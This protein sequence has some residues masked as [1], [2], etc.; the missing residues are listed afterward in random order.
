MDVDHGKTIFEIMGIEVMEWQHDSSDA[1][2]AL[3]AAEAMARRLDTSVA[4]MPDLT[5][6]PLTQAE[7]APLEIISF[8]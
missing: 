2:I 3:Q 7:G 1:V 8:G 4:I 6:V 5:V